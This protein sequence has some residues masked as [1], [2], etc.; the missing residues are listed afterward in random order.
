LYWCETWSLAL[1]EEHRS[2]VFE[3][4]MMRISDPERDEVTRGWMGR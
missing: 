3:N 1:R 2:E 4:R